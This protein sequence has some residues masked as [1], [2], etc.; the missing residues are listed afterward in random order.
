M[1]YIIEEVKSTNDV[2]NDVFHVIEIESEGYGFDGKPYKIQH[3][4]STFETYKEAKFF[5]NKFLQARNVHNINQ[6]T[7]YKG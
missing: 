7:N 3:T 5:L 6:I 4:I 1:K 2:F